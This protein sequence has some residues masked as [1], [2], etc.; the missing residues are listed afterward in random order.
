[1]VQIDLFASRVNK[2][3]SRYIS[4]D[5]DPEA[6]DIDAFT[7]SWSNFY[8]YAFPPFSLILKTLKKIILDQA[9]GIVVV[10]DWPAQP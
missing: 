7:R 5:R 6:F 3:C 8:F 4:R 9:C 2:K 1:M 10:P